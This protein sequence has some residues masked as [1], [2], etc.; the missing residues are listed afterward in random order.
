MF[1]QAIMVQTVSE[2]RRQERLAAIERERQ[3][4]MTACPTSQW[5]SF[6]VRALALVSLVLSP[7][8]C[9]RSR[10]QRNLGS[11]PLCP[12]ATN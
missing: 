7:R 11:S 10:L 12:P 3:V 5:Q 8:V 1:P 6:A 9:E 4:A 2:L